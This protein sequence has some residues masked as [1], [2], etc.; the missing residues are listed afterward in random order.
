LLVLA[1]VSWS[2]VLG[3]CLFRA[4]EPPAKA[5][6]ITGVITKVETERTPLRILIE[7]K[8]EISAGPELAGDKIY[9]SVNGTSIWVQ[10]ADGSWAVGGKADLRVGS[11]V[12]AWTDCGLVDT[13]P[14]HGCAG[15]IAILK[16]PTE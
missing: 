1:F 16:P 15:D 10:R 2:T 9:F 8:P 12:R 11:T 4:Q 7:E 3:G 6:T 5:P 14:Q 13:Y